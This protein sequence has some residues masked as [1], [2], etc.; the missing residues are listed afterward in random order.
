[1]QDFKQLASSLQSGDLTGAQQAYTA[2]QQL[3]PNQDPNSP[4]A[5]S[6]GNPISTDF[7]AL[8]QALQSGDLSSAQ[9]AFSQ[10]QDDLKSAS[11][12]G[13]SGLTHVRGHHGRHH[14]ASSAQDS[15]SSSGSISSTSSTSTTGGNDSSGSSGQI[16]NVVA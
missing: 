7:K 12:S 16:L 10:L 15:D 13:S 4:Q 14:H 6:S 11:Q 5:P 9:S 1:M 3:L 2:L 8:G